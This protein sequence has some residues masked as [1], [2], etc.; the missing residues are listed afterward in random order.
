VIVTQRSCQDSA[1]I[2]L[3]LDP[4]LSK[5][6]INKRP[7]HCNLTKMVGFVLLLHGSFPLPEVKLQQLPALPGGS[8][9]HQ[10]TTEHTKHG[11]LGQCSSVWPVKCS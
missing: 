11:T 4:Y 7:M 9:A 2:K 10:R 3:T 1:L 5:F 8:A 6:F